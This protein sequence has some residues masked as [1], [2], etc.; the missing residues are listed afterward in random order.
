MNIERIVK[1]L[2]YWTQPSIVTKVVVS[3]KCFMTFKLSQT[4]NN[5]TKQ[6]VKFTSWFIIYLLS[7]DT[8]S[9]CTVFAPSGL[10]PMVSST[11]LQKRQRTSKLKL[12]ALSSKSPVEF[13]SDCLLGNKIFQIHQL[14]HLLKPKSFDSLL[15]CSNG[16]LL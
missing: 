11:G 10:W 2:H 8:K 14:F 7:A 12:F 9:H 6:G 13:R 16:E 3:L 5:S 4:R 15:K 1:E